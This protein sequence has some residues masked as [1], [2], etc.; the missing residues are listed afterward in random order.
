MSQSIVSIVVPVYN[1]GKYLR[2]GLNSILEQTS[3]N[4]E[5]VCIDDGSTDDSYAILREYAAKDN[6]FR[7]FSKENGG[8]SRARNL[9]ILEAKGEWVTFMDADDWLSTNTV[10]TLLAAPC[11]RQV[12]IIGFDADVVYDE[13][14]AHDATLDEIFQVKKEGEYPGSPEILEDMVG[15]CW[16]KAYRR[17]FLVENQLMFP[18][19]MRQEDEVFYRCAMSVAQRVYMI[20]HQGYHYFQTKGSYMHEHTDPSESYLL[21]LQGAQITY[22]YYIRHACS[23]EWTLTLLTFLYWQFILRQGAW[24]WRQRR[25]LRRQTQPF[26]QEGHYTAKYPGDYRVRFLS[27]LPWWKDLLIRRGC[28]SERIRLLGITFKKDRYKDFHLVSSTF[29]GIKRLQS[30][31]RKH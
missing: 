23:P 9:G 3:V 19:N 26:L 21:Y 22:S 4:W 18:E 17:A 8:V 1:A 12:D 5:A 30:P 7:L 6:R 13:G 11:S 24:S 2:H 27:A 14:V 15:T 29:L 16:G 10:E 25:E 20:R 31:K 28:D